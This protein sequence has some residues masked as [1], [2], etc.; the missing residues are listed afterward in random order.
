MKT[1][2][3]THSLSAGAGQRA[4][5]VMRPLIFKRTTAEFRTLPCSCA[6]AMR[7]QAFSEEL[8]YRHGRRPEIMKSAERDVPQVVQPADDSVIEL[9]RRI[10]AAW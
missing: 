6:E 8:A 10:Q 2:L 4:G 5:M 1:R 7:T 3:G 9:F